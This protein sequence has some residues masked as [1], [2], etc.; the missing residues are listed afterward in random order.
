MLHSRF[1]DYK[2]GFAIT[3]A[4]VASELELVI[5]LFVCRKRHE[6][7]SHEMPQLVISQQFIAGAVK[8]FLIDFITVAISDPLNSLDAVA[9]AVGKFQVQLYRYVRKQ[10]LYFRICSDNA[11]SEKEGLIN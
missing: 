11:A 1:G 8:V 10:E 5:V 4:L 2:R 7:V 3:L 9:D 6:A